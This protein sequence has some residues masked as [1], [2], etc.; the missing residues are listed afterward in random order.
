MLVFYIISKSNP[1]VLS[2]GDAL[3]IAKIDVLLRSF[4]I[5]HLELWNFKVNM[6]ACKTEKVFQKMKFSQTI[7]SQE[8]KLHKISKEL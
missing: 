6:C 5:K 2:N 1:K 8:V 4:R 3:I 7:T